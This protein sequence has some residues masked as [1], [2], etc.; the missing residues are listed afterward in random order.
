MMR[1]EP[2]GE[3][4][5]PAEQ[6]DVDEREELAEALRLGRQ[7]VTTLTLQQPPD[8][9]P[10]REMEGLEVREMEGLVVPRGTR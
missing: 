9:P 1:L 6:S 7:E 2:L 3:P 4:L 10:M 5:G 8:H